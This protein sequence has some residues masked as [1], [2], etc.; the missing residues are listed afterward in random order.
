MSNV[1]ILS[2]PYWFVQP[3]SRPEDEKKSTSRPN[4]KKCRSS[5]DTDIQFEEVLWQAMKLK[6]VI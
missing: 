2:G 3:S 5:A 1:A 6:E 4:A